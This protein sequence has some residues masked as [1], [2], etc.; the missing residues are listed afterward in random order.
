MLYGISDCENIDVEHLLDVL[1]NYPAC[2]KDIHEWQSQ[3]N[4]DGLSVG[5][6]VCKTCGESFRERFLERYEGTLN[7]KRLQQSSEDNG[8]EVQNV[9]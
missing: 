5:F 4:A 6:P 1:A 3:K 7:T 8:V 9:R 2:M